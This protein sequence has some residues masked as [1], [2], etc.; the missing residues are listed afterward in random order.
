MSTTLL[1]AMQELS[2]QLG[3]SWQSTTDE[4]G[5][6]TT[7]VDSALAAKPSDWITDN[8]WA[9]LTEEPTGS[10]AIYDERKVSSLSGTTLTTLTFAAAPGTGIDYEVHRL[11]SPSEKRIAL[12]RA[13]TQ[14]YPD[15]FKEIFDESL[16][17]GNWLKDGSF[18]SWTSSSALSYWT[19]ATLTLA[20][21]STAG[22]VRTG[23]YSAKLNTAAGTLSQ[24]I[25]NNDDLLRLRGQTVVFSC[26][27]WCDAASAL[28]LSIN[29]GITQTY[30]SYHAGDSAWTADNP[31]D[32]SF[33]CQ[34]YIDRDATQVTFTIHLESAT[35]T[36]YLDDARVIG[37][38]HGKTYVGNL[39]LVQNKPHS[40]Y[41]EPTYYSNEQIWHRVR[42]FETDLN[43]NLLLPT[44]L[45]D[46]R[47]RL[48]GMGVLDFLVS[49][50]SS[51]AWT[52]TIALDQPQLSILIAAAAVE[53]Y[54]TMSMP[55][56]ESGTAQEYKSAMGYW[57]QELQT[58]IDKFA[59]PPPPCTV[60]WGVG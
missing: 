29:D 48:R 59:M 58:R 4:A 5:L 45:G 25:T 57:K 30:S 26:Q 9:F 54:T 32:N 41:I 15:L 19:K 36:A 7:L 18:E 3:D 23:T 8:T 44:T 20:Q 14:V 51:T 49:G 55:N 42:D 38:V 12:I 33:H 6:A 1:A 22:Y 56:F 2:R 27:G 39:G 50:V 31:R 28:R 21:Y 10:A 13:A 17:S 40:V 34:Q 53:L 43:G 46:L 35:A 24:T 52:A 11:F 60:S 37:G 16:V 47:L